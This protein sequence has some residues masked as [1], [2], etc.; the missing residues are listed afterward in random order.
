MEEGPVWWEVLKVRYGETKIQKY[1][2]FGQI[3]GST[4]TT[5]HL[6]EDVAESLTSLKHRVLQFP[7][8]RMSIPGLGLCES[9]F[10]L[11][12]LCP[13]CVGDHVRQK[14]L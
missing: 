7:H 12:R 10:S 8:I 2:H 4:K 11:K 13:N 6:K 1:K 3:Q 14:S 9:V 5:S